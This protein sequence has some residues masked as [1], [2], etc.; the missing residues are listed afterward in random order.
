M[1]RNKQFRYFILCLVNLKRMILAMD[2]YSFVFDVVPTF[3]PRC[4][5]TFC[6]SQFMALCRR[7]L[8]SKYCIIGNCCSRVITGPL[9]VNPGGV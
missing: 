3:Q 4:S 1:V 2:E 9:G 8:K 6:S 7:S 5:T